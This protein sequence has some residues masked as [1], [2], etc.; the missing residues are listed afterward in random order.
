MNTPIDPSKFD[1]LPAKDHFIQAIS[2]VDESVKTSGMAIGAAKG[3]L[4][5]L[6]ETLGTMIGDPDLPSHMRSGYEGALE[7][8]HELKAKIDGL[9]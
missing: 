2:H 6:T 4:Y 5:S 8:A 7:L 3:I 9:A 1:D